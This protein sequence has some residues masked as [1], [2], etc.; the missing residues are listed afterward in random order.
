MVKVCRPVPEPILVMGM[1][2]TLVVLSPTVGENLPD[3]TGD[4]L[5]TRWGLVG[6]P[7]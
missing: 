7:P 1:V 4:T 2:D 5:P 6:S 3:V